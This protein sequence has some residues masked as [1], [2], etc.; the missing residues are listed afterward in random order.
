MRCALTNDPLGLASL[1]C[2]QDGLKFRLVAPVASLLLVLLS[3]APVLVA[4]FIGVSRVSDMWHF[5]WDVLGRALAWG[6]AVLRYMFWGSCVLL[7]FV[8]NL[9]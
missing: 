3:A 7:F 5:A 9:Y 6:G 2:F 4:F 8:V 1:Y